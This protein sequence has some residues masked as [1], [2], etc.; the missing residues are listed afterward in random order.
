MA[1]SDIRTV[2]NLTKCSR[3]VAIKNLRDADFDFAEAV[4]KILLSKPKHSPNEFKFDG[5]KNV[6]V[7]KEFVK[8]QFTKQTIREFK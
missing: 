4:K 5:F 6:M 7:T 2:M 3:N 1:P 8:I